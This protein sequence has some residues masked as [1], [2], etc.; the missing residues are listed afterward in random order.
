ML[1]KNIYIKLSLFLSVFL[2]SCVSSKEYKNKEKEVQK[3]Q[4]KHDRVKAINKDIKNLLYA[5]KSKADRYKNQQENLNQVS[6]SLLEEKNNK[7]ENNKGIAIPTSLRKDLK[8][9]ISQIKSNKNKNLNTF[10]DSLNY[11]LINKFSK[12]VQSFDLKNSDDINIKIERTVVMIAVSDKLLFNSASYNIRRSGYPIIKKLAKILAAEPNINV[13]I[14]G[15]ADSVP[16]K[17]FEIKDNWDLSVK[18]ATTIAR[19]L[20]KRYKIRPE[21]LIPSGRGSAVPFKDNKT[22][23][24]RALNRRIKIFLLPNLNHF[25][26]FLDADK[27][28]SKSE[29]NRK[30]YKK[31]SKKINKFLDFL[32]NY[33]KKRKGIDTLDKCKKGEEEDCD[34]PN[35]IINLK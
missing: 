22:R 13:I 25:F 10:K 3:T 18:R 21:R 33:H 9:E 1:K 24:N 6:L 7:I 19:L 11:L 26:D 14:E 31:A 12:Q 27:M 2:M 34:D 32:K 15:H 5:V 17:T 20:E 8:K 29:I 4:E 28:T 16:I 23:K 35:K 30:E